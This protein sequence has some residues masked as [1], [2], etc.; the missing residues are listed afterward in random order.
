MVHSSLYTARLSSLVLFYHKKENMVTASSSGLQYRVTLYVLTNFGDDDFYPEGGNNRYLQNYSS[1]TTYMS[2][3]C[4][5]EYHNLNFHHREN[6][7]FHQIKHI[8]SLL[9]F[10]VTYI[11]LLRR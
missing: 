2:T 4:S 11:I 7:K 6:L 9:A 5:N 1:L 10:N 8:C 3:M